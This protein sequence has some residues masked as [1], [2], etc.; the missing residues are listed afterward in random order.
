MTDFEETYAAEPPDVSSNPDDILALTSTFPTGWVDLSEFND[1]LAAKGLRPIQ[2]FWIKAL[3]A[4]Q[5]DRAMQNG[6]V[7]LGENG[8]T[9]FDLSSMKPGASAELIAMA[10]IRGRHDTQRLFTQK[11][12]FEL[13]KSLP[14][15]VV[16]KAATAIRELSGI[17]S[18]AKDK[19]KKSSGTMESDFGM[20]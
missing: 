1:L 14:R 13:L 8:E 3:N 19:A 10:A 2:G 20:S 17:T 16:E 5:A 12:H 18:D 7:S 15:P 6:R 4:Q 9:I 11:S